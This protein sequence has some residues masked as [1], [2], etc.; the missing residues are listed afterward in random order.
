[1]LIIYRMTGAILDAAAS[2][3]S[4]HP[5]S[6]LFVPSTETFFSG[7]P[8]PP[9]PPGPKGDQGESSVLGGPGVSVPLFGLLVARG[10]WTRLDEPRQVFILL[11]H[12]IRSSAAWSRGGGLVRNSAKHIHLCLVLLEERCGEP[13]A[14]RLLWAQSPVHLPP[15]LGPLEVAASGWDMSHNCLLSPPGP[16]GPRGHQGTGELASNNP[17][18]WGLTFRD[19]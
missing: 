4:L 17:R 13:Q 16:P 2:Q 14:L 15:Q 8:G 9:G 11:P 10:I 19:P 7:P 5:H 12:P 3:T 18:G 6:K 1:M